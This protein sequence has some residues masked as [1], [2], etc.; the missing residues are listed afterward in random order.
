MTLYNIL[1]VIKDVLPRNKPY[2]HNV[3]QNGRLQDI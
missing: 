3:K 1:D 2:Y